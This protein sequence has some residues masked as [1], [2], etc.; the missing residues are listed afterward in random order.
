MISLRLTI[1]R[2]EETAKKLIAAQRQL[3]MTYT[4]ERTKG[5]AYGK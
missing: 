2:R 1:Q 3:G 5:Q 4:S